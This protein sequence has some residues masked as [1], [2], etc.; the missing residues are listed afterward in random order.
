MPE[1]RDL[2]VYVCRDPR[3]PL[4]VAWPSLRR[5]AHGRGAGAFASR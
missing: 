4:V 5:Y 2:P 1:E 3:V